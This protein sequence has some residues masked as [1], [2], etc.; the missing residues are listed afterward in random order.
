MTPPEAGA[1]TLASASAAWWI[2]AGA[3]RRR[4]LALGWPPILAFAG[5]TLLSALLP[6]HD[7]ARAVVLGGIAVAAIC[8]ARTGLIFAPLTSALAGAALA[9]AS[10]DG[11][12]A[13]AACGALGLG[14]A[15]LALYA[16]TAGRGIG[17]GD[18]RLGVGLGAGLG[19]GTGFIALGWAFGLGGAVAAVLLLAKRV[20]RGSSIRFAPFIAAGAVAALAPPVLFP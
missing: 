20:R 18:V 6:P 10:V 7:V 14:A 19:I 1:V 16:L 13:G 2:A 4:G 12:A 8:D 9:A 3:A 15:L 11:H 5:I 17:L